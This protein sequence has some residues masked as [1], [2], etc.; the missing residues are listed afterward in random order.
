L[1]LAGRLAACAALA[2]G[3][4]SIE[5]DAGG[6]PDP[7]PDSAVVTRVIDGDTIR[8]RTPT[9]SERVRVLAIDTPES[10]RPQTPVECGAKAAARLV[11]RLAGPGAIVRLTG[12][13]TQDDRDRYGRLLRYVEAG[14]RDVGAAVVAAGLADVYV[15]RGSPARRVDRYRRLLAAARDGRRGVFGSCGGDF[16]LPGR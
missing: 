14:G 15:F 10:V 6:D 11:R 13:P 16:H 12:D 9:G 4:C 1:R 8:V 5:I 2:L 7:E 3:G